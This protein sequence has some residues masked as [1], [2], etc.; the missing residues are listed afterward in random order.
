MGALADNEKSF[1]AGGA[2]LKPAPTN[3]ARSVYA[4]ETAGAMIG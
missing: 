2:G 3:L 4:V 1:N